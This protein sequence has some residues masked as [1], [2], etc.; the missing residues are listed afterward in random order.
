MKKETKR[1]IATCLLALLTLLIPIFFG[2]NQV[3]SVWLLAL[4]GLLMLGVEWRLENVI[5]YAALLLS[6]PIAEISAIYFGIWFYRDPV[7][8]GIPLWLF[9]V[10]GN[11][12]L[13][14]ARLREFIFSYRN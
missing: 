10:W 12:G 11:A 4:V 2:T 13:Y 9:L 5:F 14:I 8:M 3:L 7:F 1:F 6:G